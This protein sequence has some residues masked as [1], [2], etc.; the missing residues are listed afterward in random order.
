MRPFVP[1]FAVLALSLAGCAT[2]PGL[3]SRMAAYIGAPE[4]TLVQA[5]GVPDKQITVNGETYLAYMRSQAQIQ[6][7]PALIGPMGPYWGP[8]GG[9][10]YAAGLP[11]NILVWSCEITF[12][13]RDG[14]VAGVTLKGNDCN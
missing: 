13:V 4:A 12:L 3:Q 8:Y 14:K 7:N 2:G 10:V 11:S 9:T 5:L 6:P 1:L